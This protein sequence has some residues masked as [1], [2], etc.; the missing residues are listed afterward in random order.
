MSDL[1]LT[2]ADDNYT[3]P[4]EKKDSGDTI[5]GDAGNDI[6]RAYQGNVLGGKGNDT[7]EIIPLANE[8]WRKVTAA[9]WDGAPGKVVVDLEA[10]TAQDG[11]GGTDTLIGV[12]NVAGNWNDNQFFG[13]SKDNDF[14]V[15]GGKNVVDGRGGYDGVHLPSFSSTPSTWSEFVV[16]VSVDGL[17]AV[18]TRPGQANFSLIMSNVESLA[19]WNDVTKIESRRSLAD[20]IKPQDL[21]TDGLVEGLTYRWNAS[22]VV[23]S[24]VELTYS[25]FSAAPA[26][27][28]GAAQFRVFTAAEQ[29]AVK[30]ILATLAQS[31]GL[32][33]REVSDTATDHGALRFG[34]SQQTDSKGVTYMPGSD[35]ATAGQLWMDVDSLIGLTP[36]SEGYAALLHEIGHAMGLRHT[37]NVDASD[38]YAQQ[39]MPQFDLTSL[40]VMSQTASADG[41]FPSTLGALD[42]AALR[43]LYGTKSVNTGNNT[44]QLGGLQFLSETTLIDDGGIDTIESSSSAVGIALDLNPA[45][46]SSVG[47]TANGT[48]AT[49]NLGLG[50]GTW[51]ENAIGSNYDD[52]LVGNELANQLTGGKGNDWIDGGAGVDTAT[53]A[54][55]RNDYFISSSFGQVFVSARD[56]KAG[57][58]TLLNI[59][60]FQFAD[61]SM[62]LATN[63]LGADLSIALDQDTSITTT[64]PDPSDTTRELVH[65]TV[66]A[67]P[68]NGSLVLSDTG[69]FT[70]TPKALFAAADSFTYTLSDNKN[71]HNVYTTFIQV[72]GVG[73]EQQGG[74][75]NDL[76]LGSSGDENIKALAGD[77]IVV[78]SSGND[79]IDGGTGMDIVRYAVNHQ[80]Y[81]IARNPSGSVSV[82]KDNAQGT[83]TLTN[84]ERLAFNDSN[85]ALDISGNAGQAFRIYQA[86][87]DRKPDLVGL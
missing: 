28:V 47:V 48:L 43:Y 42:I 20:F 35:A 62:V 57:F 38:H 81:T 5:F 58:D 52:V 74:G 75:G 10:G 3:Q 33:F 56:G 79:N 78:G 72:R 84:V 77:D 32:T 49:N 27:G 30:N 31:T 73:A 11:W 60:K 64:L 14:W 87:L 80:D 41:L 51:I 85:V 59:E 86:A 15:G 45:H 7:I 29:A 24:S 36:G 16:K 66:L 70:Y 6:L 4:L 8:A 34:A 18:V 83:D 39:F 9:Y 61:Q 26:S 63:A 68:K 54:G 12:Q 44:Y 22:K 37:K 40:T 1:H 21:A 65:Y 23:G 82:E 55:S 53:F 46:L 19:I 17:S 76:L 71:N 2:D 25:F 67:L 13:S 50:V 69:E